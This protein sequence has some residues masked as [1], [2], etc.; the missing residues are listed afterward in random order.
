VGDCRQQARL[1][2]AEVFRTTMTSAATARDGMRDVWP[3]RG[4]QP[5]RCGQ[6]IETGESVAIRRADQSHLRRARR[7]LLGPRCRPGKTIVARWPS[8]LLTDRRWRTVRSAFG[9][10]LWESNFARSLHRSRSPCPSV[11]RTFLMCLALGRPSSCVNQRITQ[12]GPV[13]AVRRACGQLVK[14]SIAGL[15]VGAPWE[16]RATTPTSAGIEM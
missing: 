10:D 8:T 5:T 2:T 16:A 11:R 12:A 6:R 15:G 14:S 3:T 4:H 9:A 13:G 1:T 7:G